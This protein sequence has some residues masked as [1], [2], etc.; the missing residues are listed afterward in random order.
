M[1]LTTNQFKN[2]QTY[3]KTELAWMLNSFFA[4][5]TANKKFN[6]FENKEAQLGDSITFDLATRSM[7]GNGLVISQ[8]P[9]VQRVQTLTCTQAA[10][11]SAAFSAQQYIFNANSYLDRFDESKIKEIG[12]KVE[13]D[14]L[15]NIISQSRVNDPQN[16]L[17]GQIIDPASGPY[18]FF[19][20]SNGEADITSYQQ[21]DQAIAN[22]QDY[23]ASDTNLCGAI[24][25][26]KIPAIIGNG[27]S[28][29][30]PERNNEIAT[31]WMLGEFGGANW[32]K[33]NLLPIHYAGTV[34]NTA[35]TGS[36][37]TLISTND[38]TGNNI[39]QL[40]LG[41]APPNDPNA[42]KIG[43]LMYFID[44]VSGQNDMRYLSFIG[45]AETDQPVQIRATSNAAADGSGNVTF[46]IY[47]ALQSTPG[48]NQNL[49]HALNAGMKVEVM[50]SH[51]AGILMSGNPLYLAMPRLPDESPFETS[52]VVD[53][54]TGVSI[55]HY[56]GSQF[57]Q[58]VRSYVHDL[59]WASTFVAENG[60]RLVFPL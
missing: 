35:G 33:S 1:A 53:E 10:F 56:W 21:L 37:L 50:P 8:Q 34:G 60:M 30:A 44:G 42:I 55:R 39:T 49:N 24:P 47:P 41:G 12:T 20:V 27:L 18:R 22:F 45:H 3:Q 16:P 15:M 52:T 7:T 58:N 25:M 17:Y 57:G 9:S 23:G 2:V 29:F 38:P 48:L 36:N 28:Q 59:I 54:K 43:D 51:R 14:I 5:A 13:K 4:I 19:A 32:Y 31:S 40:T 26:V 46:N 6:D 11:S